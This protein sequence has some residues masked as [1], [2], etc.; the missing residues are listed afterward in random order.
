MPAQTV[1]VRVAIA[2]RIE[3]HVVLFEDEDGFLTPVPDHLARA[4]AAAVVGEPW[5]N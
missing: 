3:R 4:V 1:D 5:P 2:V